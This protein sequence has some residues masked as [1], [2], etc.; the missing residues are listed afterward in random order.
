L[1]L[2]PNI[3]AYRCK[4]ERSEAFKIRQSAFP[5]GALPQTPLDR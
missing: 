2:P 4:K 1:A 3:S 5:T